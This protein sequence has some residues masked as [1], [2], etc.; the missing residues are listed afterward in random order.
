MMLSSS[1]SVSELF[2]LLFLAF[3]GFFIAVTTF[4]SLPG[5]GANVGIST[6]P[7]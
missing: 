2:A 7:Y 6:T 1:P 5:I 4:S 3:F